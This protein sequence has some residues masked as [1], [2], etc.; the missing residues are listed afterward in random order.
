MKLKMITALLFMPLILSAG[1]FWFPEQATAQKYRILSC[2][3]QTDFITGAALQGLVARAVN[4]GKCDELLIIRHGGNSATE[5][6]WIRRTAERLSAHDAGTLTLVEAVKHFRPLIEGYVLYS[7]DVSAGDFYQFRSSI[8]LSANSATM[9]A[10]LFNALPVTEQQEAAF[11]NLG[12]KNSYDVRKIPPATV[13]KEHQNKFNRQMLASLDPKTGNLRDMI[14]AH[15]ISI[16]FGKEDADFFADQMTPPFT[17]LGWGAGD[18]F[19]HVEPFSRRGGI[20]SVSNW[21]KNLTFLSAAAAGY[22][23]EKIAVAKSV[24]TAKRRTVSFMLSDGDNTG[25]MMGNFW[26]TNY[27]KSPLT[28]KFPMGF[29]VALASLAQIAPVV[30][31]RIAAEQPDNVSL[32]EF[33][34]GY[35]YPDLFPVDALREHARRLNIQMNR[36]GARLLCFI[37]NDS[38]SKNAQT[39]YQIFA[40]EIE[41]LDGMMVMD[42]A[43]YHKGEGKIYWT[44]NRTGEL[45]PAVTARF[46]MWDGMN[47]PRAG[48]PETVAAAVNA[49]TETH[50][51]VAVH[52]W[53]KFPRTKNS[54]TDTGVYAVDRCIQNIDTNK[55]TVVSPDEMFRLIR[56]EKEKST[57]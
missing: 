11:K 3:S 56:R 43:P 18:E 19:K 47:R 25:W 14:V 37:M 53:S 45:I 49:D 52:A 28:G 2:S 27:F 57:R 41:T 51:W 4:A 39:A 40:D 54:G 20:E 5:Q 31:D 24:D 50:S 22:Q 42:Y 23:P 35:F 15:N 30:V 33:S 9:L 34:G 1:D 21:A 12:L 7:E 17:V 55:V 48:T 32:I 44:K 6:E 29:S 13:F 36:T 10:G 16:G 46:A 38:A 8:N 26:N